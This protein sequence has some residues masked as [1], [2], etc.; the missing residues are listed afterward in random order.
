ALDD[1][2]GEIDPYLRGKHTLPLADPPELLTRLSVDIALYRMVDDALGNTDE[3]RKRYEDALKTL[4]RISSG[5][6]VLDIEDTEPSASGG[7]VISGPGRRF[8]R[9]TM[10]GL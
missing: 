8:T 1:A 2:A 3:R 6:M 4:G 5:A 9:D 7:V 10:A